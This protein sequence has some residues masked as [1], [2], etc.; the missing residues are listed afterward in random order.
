LAEVLKGLAGQMAD[1]THNRSY[2]GAGHGVKE[3][4]DVHVHASY[5]KKFYLEKL[6]T[7]WN[8][9][10][11]T[12]AKDSEE[13]KVVDSIFKNK[14]SGLDDGSY[15]M[16]RPEVINTI[17]TVNLSV[18][19]KHMFITKFLDRKRSKASGYVHLHNVHRKHVR[20]PN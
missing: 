17:H 19:R 7:L 12:N 14:F 18:Q 8:V 9:M 6:P 13:I 20:G 11:R 15:F 2:S 3:T 5:K 1:M 10:P 16:W 4:Y